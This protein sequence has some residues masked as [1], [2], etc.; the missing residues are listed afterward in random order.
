MAFP[1]CLYSTALFW[2]L[3]ELIALE[4]RLLLS[5]LV[6]KLYTS[7]ILRFKKYPGITL[8]ILISS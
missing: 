3:I 4:Y 2:C 1:F 8:Y 5:A 6:S 7:L